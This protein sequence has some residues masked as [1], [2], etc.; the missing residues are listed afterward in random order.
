MNRPVAFVTGA[1]RGIGAATALELA[2]QGYD[3]AL[4]GRTAEALDGVAGQ[5]AL[6]GG[7]A[8]ALPGDLADLEFAE[9]AVRQC[10]EKFGR[11]DVLVNNAAWR[12]IASMR[13]ISLDSWEKTLRVCLTAP[14]FLSRWA[15]EHMQ[16]RGQGTIVNVSSIM[17]EQ[18][19]GISPAYVACKGALDALTYELAALYGPVGIRVVGVRPGAIDTDMSRELVEDADDEVRSF[20][21]NMISLGRWGTPEE[22]ARVIAFVASPAASYI[23]GTNLDID[24]GWRHQ[25]LPLSLKR[26]QYPRDFP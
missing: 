11:I 20:S 1:S 16:R 6:A 15:A 19:A 22:V 2:R 23:H 10:H 8:L 3:L 17:S 7:K 9:S 25:H 14:A 5:V 18:A 13:D 4:L 21:E 24:G 12:E 26:G